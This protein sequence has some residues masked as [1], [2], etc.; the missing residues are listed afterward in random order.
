MEALGEEHKD[1]DDFGLVDALSSLSGVPVPRAVEEIRTAP[2]FHD[3]VVDAP[4]MPDAVRDI[5]AIVH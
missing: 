4:D 1:L 5:L 2:V 3:R